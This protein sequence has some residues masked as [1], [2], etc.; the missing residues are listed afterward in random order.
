[1]KLFEKTFV[2]DH[3]W[4]TVTSAFW[5]KYP[6][7]LQPHVLRVDTLD[8]DIDPEK[9][10]FA[11]RRLHSLKYSV[12]KWMECFFGGSSPVGFGLEEAYCSLPDK[13]LRLRSQNYTFSSFFRV[14]EECVYTPHPTDPSRTLYKQTATYKVFGLGAAINRAL[15]RAAVRS[16]EEKSSVGFSVVQS[17]ASSLAE[18]G[19]WRRRCAACFQS[20]E[21][22]AVN[23]TQH[24]RD[25][26]KHVE[27][28]LYPRSGSASS[29][30]SAPSAPP[31]PPS[32]PF[33]SASSLPSLLFDRFVAYPLLE[34]SLFAACA[35]STSAKRFLLGRLLPPFV[36]PA[37]GRDPASSLFSVPSSLR[38]SLLSLSP[39]IPLPLN[40][41]RPARAAAGSAQAPRLETGDGRAGAAEAG[42]DVDC[43]CLRSAPGGTKP[44]STHEWLTR[45]QKEKSKADAR[46]MAPEASAAQRG[47][48]GGDLA[49]G[50]S[51]SSSESQE[52]VG[53]TGGESGDGR[54][55]G[56]AHPGW[57]QGSENE[58][59]PC[60]GRG[61][62][63]LFPSLWRP[64]SRAPP[65]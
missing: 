28:S 62:P 20:L 31:S 51:S 54:A 25:L 16:A 50:A 47:T 48:V 9:Q 65:R 60:C 7:E 42:A 21:T 4:E 24:Y 57:R 35:M 36:L 45:R 2:F 59:G 29:Q 22:A 6:N 10:E 53:T 17:R 61:R 40:A 63:L 33:P 30:C 1:M 32:S 39:S 44:E 46:V 8:V 18:Q 55:A 64:S 19:W 56:A 49:C 41:L 11:T 26:V 58:A 13:V 38:A 15:E 14:D 23:A 52:T 27:A 37:E 12:P 34:P 5:T 3:N 43:P